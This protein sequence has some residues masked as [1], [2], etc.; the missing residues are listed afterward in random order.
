VNRPEASAQPA[1]SARSGAFQPIAGLSGRGHLLLAGFV[2]FLLSVPFWGGSYIVTV[3]ILILYL[4][5]VGQSWNLM[6]GFAG[7]LSIGHALFIGIGSYAAAYLFAKQGIPPVLGVFVAVALAV[8]VGSI[9]GYLGFR[10]SISG[11][12]FALLTIAFAEFARIMVDHAGFLNGTQGLFLPVSAEDSKGIDLINLR[13]HPHM[14][15]YLLMVLTLG[16][17]G[18]CRWLLR[19]KLGYYW[20]AIRDDQE[21]AQALGINVFRYKMYA[22]MIS[23][24]IAGLA[25]VFYAFYSNS[26]FPES[27]FNIER[28]IE[29]TLAPIVGGVGTLFGPILGAFIL[30]PLG[31]FITWVIDFLKEIGWIDPSLK[32]NGLKLLIW[33]F[34]V[35]LIVLFKPRGLWPWF[36]DRFRLLRGT[37]DDG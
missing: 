26:L 5:L 9:I 7:L 2:L 12:Y 8:L 22:V 27:T 36:R 28:S 33:G 35:V 37:G 15:Y 30:T 25:G 18:L 29:V 20:Q 14:F 11:V 1:T 32:L 31:E 17:L 10:F 6:L 24:A 4:A 19:S 16:T 3:G 23:S 13:G 21:A 34:V